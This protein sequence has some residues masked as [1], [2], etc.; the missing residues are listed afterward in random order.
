MILDAFG[1]YNVMISTAIWDEIN[2]LRYDSV[3]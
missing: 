3:T 1:Y 2:R